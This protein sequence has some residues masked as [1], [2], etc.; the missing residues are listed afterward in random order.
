M[1]R[2][3]SVGLTTARTTDET[4]SHPWRLSDPEKCRTGYLGKS[5]DL[6]KCL[7]ES[8]EACEYAFRFGNGIICHHP[9]RR[10]FEKTEKPAD[11]LSR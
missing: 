6:W 7:V 10:W 9:D 4:V 5:L 2:R 11:T 3:S 1:K 8:P